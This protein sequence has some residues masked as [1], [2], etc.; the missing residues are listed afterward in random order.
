MILPCA[1][2]KQCFA[3]AD[4]IIAHVMFGW[5]PFGCFVVGLLYL[6]ATPRSVAAFARVLPATYAP[7]SA[8]VYLGLAFAPWSEKAAEFPT[9]AF[10]ALHAVP[11]V[12]LAISLRVFRGPR[13]VH[14]ILVPVAAICMTWQFA[15]AYWGI[16]GK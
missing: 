12:L 3:M 2:T 6:A 9:A 5:A 10:F 15:L 1:Q 8:I 13:W 7:L 4:N 11:L 16:Y 14:T